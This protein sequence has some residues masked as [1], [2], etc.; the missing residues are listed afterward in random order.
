[1]LNALLGFEY[2]HGTYPDPADATPGS[3]PGGYSLADWQAIM[4]DPDA[5]ALAHPDLVNVQ[6]TGDTK[7]ITITP[8]VLPLVAPLH[9][10]GLGVVADL[11]EPF[12]R[13]LIEQTG[14]DRSIPYGQQ[15]P[16]RIIPFFNP[17]QLA[18]DLIAAI[19]QGIN[20]AITNL[21]NG[22]PPVNIITDGTVA[23]G[24][25]MSAVTSFADPTQQLN[26]KTSSRHEQAVVEEDNPGVGQDIGDTN[27]E[28]SQQNA[29]LATPPTQPDPPVVKPDTNDPQDENGSK[30]G[31]V[32]KPGDVNKPGDV[33]KPG[34]VNKPGDVDKPGDVNKPGDDN[35]PGDV[36]KPGDDNKPGDVNKP[37][38]DNK[39]SENQKAAA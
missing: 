11:V 2:V 26:S 8:R 25:S 10:I 32:D 37:G 5:V 24:S 3:T 13:V 33:D 17:I 39:P 9:Q 12:L 22:G 36:N 15:T 27:D 34:D 21:Q 7:Y 18:V 29:N 14:Y 31:D 35:K 28:L 19:P 20:Q 30:P 23:S 38:D 16:F 4:D 6:Q 1:M